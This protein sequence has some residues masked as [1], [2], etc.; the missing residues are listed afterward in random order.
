MV[1][2]ITVSCP[3]QLDGEFNTIILG[4]LRTVAACVWI[5]YTCTFLFK[6]YLGLYFLDMTIAT[7]SYIYSLMYNNTY[8]LLMS[9]YKHSYALH[10]QL[11]SNQ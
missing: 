6:H 5:M 3:G 2:L 4:H 9:S 1:Y 10:K 11:N 7:F 8:N